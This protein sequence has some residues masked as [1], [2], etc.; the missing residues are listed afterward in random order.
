MT[1]L[2]WLRR[3]VALLVGLVA[4]IAVQLIFVGMFVPGIV[5]A[6]GGGRTR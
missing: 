3:S 5:D 4:A 1:E 6:L 2:P